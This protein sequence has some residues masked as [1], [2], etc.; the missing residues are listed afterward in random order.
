MDKIILPT[1]TLDIITKPID[2]RTVTDTIKFNF[3]F[4][5]IPLPLTYVSRIFLYNFVFVNQLF[6]LSELLAKQNAE[7]SKKGTE[8]IR[9]KTAPI[10][11]KP[12]PIQPNTIYNIF[13]LI[14]EKCVIIKS[15]Y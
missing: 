10:A 2:I 11:P 14:T 7:S 1:G 9:G 6:N 5:V 4:Q 15:K 12:T 3:V 8:G 13:S